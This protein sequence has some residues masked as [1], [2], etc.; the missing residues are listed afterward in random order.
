MVDVCDQCAIL[1][2]ECNSMAR[3]PVVVGVWTTSLRNVVSTYS[4]GAM[5]YHCYSYHE[6]ALTYNLVYIQLSVVI[7]IA[8]HSYTVINQVS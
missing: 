4:H 5:C 6:G 3:K 7:P 2:S 1:Q 8:N